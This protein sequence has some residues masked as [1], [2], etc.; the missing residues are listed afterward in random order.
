MTQDLTPIMKLTRDLR[1]A[2]QTLSADEA[3]FLVDA[4]YMMQENRIRADSQIRALTKSGEPHSVLGWLSDN[5]DGL[6]SG[7][8]SALDRYSASHAIGVWARSQKGIGP[9]IASGLMAHIDINKAPTA[10]HIWNFAGLNPG[11]EWKKGEKRPW[12]AA[13]KTLCWKIGESFVKVSGDDEAFYGVLYRERKQLEQGRNERGEFA[14][15]AK[16]A[17]AKKRFG[18]DTKARKFYEEGKLPPAHVH[19]RAKRWTVKIFLSHL[20]AVWHEIEF[21]KPAPVPYA[22]AHLGHAH[23]LKPPGWPIAEERAA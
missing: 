5:A 6:E 3:R 9:V 4:Y 22:I 8:K 15:A 23:L 12:N 13:L 21:G 16:A 18:D 17:L 11:V 2:A 7:I 1:A 20:H 10:G 14:E 19:A